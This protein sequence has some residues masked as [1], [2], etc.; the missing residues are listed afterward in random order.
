MHLKYIVQDAI[1]PKGY[2]LI[3]CDVTA[4]YPQ[5]PRHPAVESI[6]HRLEADPDLKKRTSLSPD[7]LIKLLEVILRLSYFQWK[8]EY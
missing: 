7:Q 3:S 4:L 6:R 8:G 2:I 1:I 5:T